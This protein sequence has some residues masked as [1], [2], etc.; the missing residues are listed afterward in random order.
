MNKFVVGGKLRGLALLGLLALILTG[1]ATAEAGAATPQEVVVSENPADWTPYVSDGEVRAI[2]Q[3]GTKV[4]V[5]G[6]FTQFQEPGQPLI[7]RTGLFAADATNGRI[8][9]GFS[10]VLNGVVHTL[11]AAPDGNLFVGGSFTQVNGVARTGLVKLDAATGAT[12]ASFTAR[13]NGEVHELALSGNRLFLAGYFGTVNGVARTKAAA[14]DRTTGALDPS[15]NFVFSDPMLNSSGVGALQVTDLALTPDGSR[16]IAIGNFTKVGGVARAQVALFDVTPSAITLANW[17]T[18]RFA[19]KCPV[20]FTAFYVRDVAVDPTGTYFVIVTTGGYGREPTPL[21]DTATRWELAQSGSGLQP[22]WVNHTGGDTLH[23]VGITANAV[24][25]GGH[26]RWQNNPFTGNRAG[27]GAVPR[28]GIAALDPVNGLPLSWNPTRTRGDGLKVFHVTQDGIWVGSDTNELGNEWHPKLGFFPAAGG[29]PIP[30]SITGTVPGDLYK[31]GPTDV[32]TR[33]PFSGMSVGPSSTVAAGVPAWSQARGTYEIS[34][35]LFSGW[36]DSKLYVRDFDGGAPGAATQV[37]L[38]GLETFNFPVQAV[39]GMFFD[40][41]TSRLYYIQ[42]GDANLYYRYFTFESQVVGALRFSVPSGGVAWNLVRGMTVASGRIYYADTS[43]NLRS[44]GFANGAPVSGTGTLIS[45]PAIGDGRTWDAKGLFV[46]NQVNKAPA[47]SFTRSCTNL[48]CSFD[49]SGSSDPDG[50]IASYSWS[51][52]DGSTATGATASHTYAAAG[53][54]TVTLTV[55]D[56][57]GATST[58]TQQVTVSAPASAEWE[59]TGSGSSTSGSFKSHSFTVTTVPKVLYL[60]LDWDNASA[61]LNLFLKD[62]NGVTVAFA[63][64]S[65]FKPEVVQYTATIAGTWQANVSFKS[66]SA[67]YRLLINPTNQPPTASFT[68]SCT[69]L[70]C[71]FDASGSSDGDGSIAS[72]AWTFGDGNTGSGQKPSH[73]YAAAGTYT[74][75]LTVTDNQGA[76]ATTTRSVTVTAP[77]QAPTASFTSNCTLLACSFDGSG[78]SDPDGSI[79]SYAWNFGDGTTGSGQKPSH[80]YALPGTYTVELTVT[81]NQGATATTTTSVTVTALPPSN[82]PPTASFSSS[83]TNLACSFDGSGSSDGD[84]SIAS[85]AWTFGDGT[86]GTGQKPDHT[87]AAAGTYTVELT[88]TDNEGATGTTTSSVTVTAPSGGVAY[89]DAVIADAPLVYWRFSETSGTS[90]KDES[91]NGHTGT[92][93]NTVELGQ[94]GLITGADPSALFG[95]TDAVTTPSTASLSPTAAVTVEA[96]VRPS[97]LPAT[98]GSFR[99]IAVKS[100]SVYLRVEHVGGRP[101]FRFMIYPPGGPW[102]RLSSAMAVQANTTYHLVGTYNGSTLRLYVNGVLDGSLSYTGTISANTNNFAAGLWG[103]TSGHW[104]GHI[105]ELAMYGTALTEER[106]LAHYQA[107]R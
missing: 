100:L 75:E 38:Y 24:Y 91:G 22:T 44:I 5:G 10:P 69:D 36:S 33:Q 62:P 25:I 48:S 78:S 16:L 80:T 28:E 23:S 7:T 20:E 71:S 63:N 72:Y 32:L 74:V 61:D 99:T 64:G 35:K 17:S 26:Q 97:A 101:V 11:A 6:S 27:P 29:K 19:P 41:A 8:D 87:Y 88:V 96:W 66:G 4:Y 1:F 89:R 68:S 45:G 53:T 46:F 67:S 103:S 21:C 43:G 102:Q 86:T 49:G 18:D 34:G 73:T 2:V 37:P 58:S 9:T 57:G 76:T 30:P 105:D 82:Q 65:T 94:Q 85:Y 56:N 54:Y 55:T 3:I 81:D 95:Q 83:C 98:E 93:R 60:Q 52:G 47:A 12:I 15:F 13:T 70:G 42:S 77:N 92:V 51:F 79:A 40:R 39:N 84:G 107:G 106:V 104:D 31:A 14:V 50:T 90:I 59:F